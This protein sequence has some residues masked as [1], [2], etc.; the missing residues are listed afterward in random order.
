MMMPTMF[1]WKIG[2][3]LH[4]QDTSPRRWEPSATHRNS[5][6]TATSSRVRRC[7]CSHVENQR[8]GRNIAKDF[9]NLCDT[10]G[11]AHAPSAPWAGHIPKELGAL[12]TLVLISLSKNQLS[13]EASNMSLVMGPWWDIHL[14]MGGIS[15]STSAST[16]TDEIIDQIW[17]SYDDAA[18]CPE[19]R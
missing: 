3:V 18:R 8:N 17:R 5:G 14:E 10:K 16:L 9:C 12:S 15:T 19:I 4:D 11:L 13:G 1:M 7:K 2:V 6:S